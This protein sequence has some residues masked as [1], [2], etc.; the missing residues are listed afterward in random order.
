[1]S[2]TLIASTVE[3]EKV[4]THATTAEVAIS[5]TPHVPSPL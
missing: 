5:L 1:M 2:E 3:D 4:V